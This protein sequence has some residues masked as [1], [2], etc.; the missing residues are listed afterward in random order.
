MQTGKKTFSETERQDV[1]NGSRID[2]DLV[3]QEIGDVLT[4]LAVE[5]IMGE[6]CYVIKRINSKGDELTE[7][8]SLNS[9]LLTQIIK[10]EIIAEG[11]KPI[12]TTIQFSD[13]KDYDGLKF[14]SRQS[15]NSGGQ[16]IEFKVN[17][18]KL[19]EKL[20]AKDFIWQE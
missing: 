17:S 14:P 11:A 9:G 8:Y 1:I 16:N 3:Y 4:I 12:I 18:I 6:D 7:F 2:K 10:S 13:Y 20:K 5:N 19:N 15:M